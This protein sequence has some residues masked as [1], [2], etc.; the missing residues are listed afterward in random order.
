MIKATVF[1]GANHS[2]WDHGISNV[3]PRL[4]QACQEALLAN[5]LDVQEQE[6][7]SQ[8]PAANPVADKFSWTG[9]TETPTGHHTSTVD[10]HRLLWGEEG[11]GPQDRAGDQRAAVGPAA[12]RR[13][14]GRQRRQ[15][16]AT[17]TEDGEE[18]RWRD[19]WRHCM[20]S[21]TGLPPPQVCEAGRTGHG[22]GPSSETQRWELPTRS[23][24]QDQWPA[25][26]LHVG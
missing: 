11:S 23:Y 17:A 7:D 16:A 3:L 12:C 24:R 20:G 14:V 18:T 4:S 10:A 21:G 26:I 25:E 2:F 15:R 8:A 22:G 13:H 1:A 6:E 19:S 9:E 5:P